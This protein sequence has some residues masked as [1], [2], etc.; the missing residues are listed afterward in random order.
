MFAAIHCHHIARTGGVVTYVFEILVYIYRLLCYDKPSGFEAF[1]FVGCYEPYASLRKVA[2][3]NKIAGTFGIV[4]DTILVFG[5][6]SIESSSSVITFGNL[7]LWVTP[8]ESVT[9]ICA[10]TIPAWQTITIAKRYI[11]FI[12][13][14]VFSFLY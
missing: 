7:N 8:E 2:I 10:N 12:S 6:K 1:R 13:E 9:L 11:L 4:C 14:I 3:H 5:I